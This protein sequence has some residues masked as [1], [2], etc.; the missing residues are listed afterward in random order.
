M[1]V[2]V[3]W[4]NKLILKENDFEE[5]TN[6]TVA[7]IKENNTDILDKLLIESG[8]SMYELL[9]LRDNDVRDAIECKLEIDLRELVSKQLDE[10]FELIEI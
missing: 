3:D 7:E 10:R 9:C 4:K 2:Y 1:T 8:H 6:D 5:L